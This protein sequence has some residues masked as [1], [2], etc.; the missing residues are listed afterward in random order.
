MHFG[1]M[2]NRFFCLTLVFLYALQA[3]TILQS[4]MPRVNQ[5][6]QQTPLLQTRMSDS[7]LLQQISNQTQSA[8]QVSRT[9]NKCY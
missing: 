2:C 7:T 6:L 8:P 5:S 1:E 9:L 3:Q 4:A